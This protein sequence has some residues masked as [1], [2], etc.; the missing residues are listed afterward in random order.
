MEMRLVPSHSRRRTSATAYFAAARVRAA[1]A[2]AALSFLTIALSLLTTASAFWSVFFAAMSFAWRVLR[3][4]LRRSRL[5][6]LG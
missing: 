1:A 6:L 5:I 3:S 4:I 2:N